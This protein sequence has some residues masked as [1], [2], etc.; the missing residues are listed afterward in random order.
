MHFTNR[1]RTGAMLVMLATFTSA[2]ADDVMMTAPRGGGQGSGA[3]TS[4]TVIETR[5][6]RAGEAG[7]ALGSCGNLASPAGSTV[8]F[9]AYA[10][11]VQIY[12]WTGTAWAFVAPEATLSA[13]ANGNGVT[14]THFGGPTWRSHGGSSVKGTVL[15]RCTPDEGAIPWLSLTAVPDGGAGMFKRVTFIQR[16]NTVGGLVPVAAGVAVGDIARV[17]YTAEYWFY[18]AP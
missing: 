4:G 8:A 1:I 18:R 2:C 9:H 7:V 14:G 6:N 17:P 11:G 16:V 10:R 15:D 5:V 12:R 13:D 3:D